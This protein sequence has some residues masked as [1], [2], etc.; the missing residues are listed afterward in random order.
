MAY[1][2]MAYLKIMIMPVNLAPFYNTPES[3]NE[4]RGLFFYLLLTLGFI[5]LTIWSAKK[6]KLILFGIMFFFISISLSF[7]LQIVSIRDSLI[8]DRYLYL[9]L[10]GF[11]LA[12][13]ILLNRIFKRDFSLLLV[14]ILVPFVYGT[15]QRVQVFSNSETLWTDAINKNYN[16]PL[17]YNNRGHFYR[18][19]DRIDE[20]LADYNEALKI[21]PN[22][23]LSLNNRGKVYFDR[24]QV[25]QAMADFNKS[26]SVAP[27][28][29]SALS[30]RGAAHAA[31]GDFDASLVDLNLA[32]EI[33]PLNTNSLSNRA[34]IYYSLNQFENAIADIT[35]YLSVKPDD[36][37]MLNLRSLCYNRLDRDQEALADLNR[38]IQLT[39]SQGVF[40]QNRSFLLN[41]MGDKTGALRDI[42][43]AEALGV[44][45][46][47]SFLQM[48]QQ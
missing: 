17:A 10:P 12:L 2:L 14:L 47:P 25:D 27:R 24:G 20:A 22:Y 31:R 11:F 29:V 9:A 1:S 19:N 18:Q 42:R 39:P 30:N 26:L 46:N 32:L 37:D 21:N 41:K 36:A 16:N 8:Y 5:A 15:V 3:V 33:E 6:Q 28:F 4:I 43:Q 48:L 44:Q 7:A 23:Y 34:L 45:V 35:T 13:M 40:W 38:A